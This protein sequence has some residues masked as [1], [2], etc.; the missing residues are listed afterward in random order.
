MLPDYV[1]LSGT[2]TRTKMSDCG[3]S[4]FIYICNPF[5]EVSEWS[6]VPDSKSG[7]PQGTGGS[8]PSLSAKGCSVGQPF[9]LGYHSGI[10]NLASR[11]V[12][13]PLPYKKMVKTINLKQVLKYD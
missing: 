9:F 6:N 11:K 4:V 7:V 2:L 3:N 8:N 10:R 12:R 13:A 1:R 5:G